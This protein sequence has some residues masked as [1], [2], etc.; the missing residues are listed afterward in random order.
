MLEKHKEVFKDELGLIK[1]VSAKTH[2]DPTARPWFHKSRSLPQV[3]RA[4]VQ[5]ELTRLEKKGV[6]TQVQFSD[7][8]A[9][10]VPVI[11]RNGSVRI[12]GDYKV[13]TNLATNVDSYPLPKI[14]HLLASLGQ[15]KVFSKLDL[16]HAYQQVLLDEESS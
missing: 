12:C 2:V 1:G 10:V 16:A 11:K 3:L 4:K 13:T 15:G 14:D 6:I 5:Q 8:A 9:P 7:W